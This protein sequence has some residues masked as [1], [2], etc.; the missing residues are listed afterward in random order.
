MKLTDISF[1]HTVLSLLRKEAKLSGFAM[2]GFWLGEPYFDYANL[3]R[4]RI[5]YNTPWMPVSVVVL[6]ITY[7]KLFNISRTK[8]VNTVDVKPEQVREPRFTQCMSRIQ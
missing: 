8:K 3:A 5:K 2:T 7:K 6:R 1:G 4:L